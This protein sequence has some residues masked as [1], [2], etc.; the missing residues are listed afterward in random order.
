MCSEEPDRQD[1]CLILQARNQSIVIALDVEHNPASLQNA[2]LGIRGLD[3]LW[4]APLSVRDNVEPGIVLRSCCF[5]SSMAGMVG[6]IAFDHICANDDHRSSFAQNSKNWNDQS[7]RPNRK[8]R[9]LRITC[10]AA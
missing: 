2:R 8:I 10:R 4:I 7:W 1:A 9:G 3:V 6:K 5:D